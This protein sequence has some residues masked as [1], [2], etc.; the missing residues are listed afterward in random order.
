MSIGFEP[1]AGT[2]SPS[3]SAW[4]TGC[5]YK[6]GEGGYHCFRIPAVVRTKDRSTLLAFAE[7]RRKDCAD[8]G[9]IDVVLK[10]STDDGKTW[11]DIELVADGGGDTRGTRCPSWTVSPGGSRC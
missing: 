10:R 11:G 7:G 2:R 5:S 3:I 1:P 9:D 8:T 6:K 4:F